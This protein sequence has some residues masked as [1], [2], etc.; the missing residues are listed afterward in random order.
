MLIPILLAIVGLAACTGAGYY[1]RKKQ[2]EEKNKDLVQKSEQILSDAKN[3]SKEII[4][5]ARNEALK[6]QDDIKKEEQRTQSKLTE[7]EERLMKKESG[8]D[9]K[10]EEA[11]KMRLEL[12]QKV[13][14]VRELRDEV[15]GIYKLQSQQL[16]KISGMTKEEAREVWIARAREMIQRR[17]LPASDRRQ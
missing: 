14:S 1:Y 5:E 6:L 3:K 17:N 15:E 7:V 9:K 11:E 10:N 12:D 16:E 2:V 13:A 8:L 4:Y